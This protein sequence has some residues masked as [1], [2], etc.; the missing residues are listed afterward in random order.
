MTTTPSRVQFAQTPGRAL[1]PKPEVDNNMS[2]PYLKYDPKTEFTTAKHRMEDV[3]DALNDALQIVCDKYDDDAGGASH[4]YRIQA[5]LEQT[6]IP[7]GIYARINFQHGPRNKEGSIPGVTDASVLA[8]LIHRL[9]AFQNFIYACPENAEALEHLRAA[10]T[11]LQS[12]TRK[13]HEQGVL[14]HN[15][16]HES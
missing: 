7:P 13:R 14:G 12:R 15:K 5:P 6:V 9:N 11:A 1:R 16:T 8:I 4:H 10:M 3:P 2:E